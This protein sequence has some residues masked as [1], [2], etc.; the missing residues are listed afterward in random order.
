MIDGEPL[1]R[2]RFHQRK[3]RAPDPARETERTQQRPGQRGFPSTQSPL[4]PD[5]ESPVCD[6]LAV[7][8]NGFRQALPE[9]LR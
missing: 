5:I 2:I 1:N 4:Q 3:G 9:Q 7:F 6:F 8:Q